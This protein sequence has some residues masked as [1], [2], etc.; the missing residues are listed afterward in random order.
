MTGVGAGQ[1]CWPIA[2][3]LGGS[4]GGSR[5]QVSS[6]RK[7]RMHM[8]T[9]RDLRRDVCR[10][11]AV[12]AGV[13]G[14]LAGATG[15]SAGDGVLNFVVD[16]A[17][18]DANMDGF[19]TGEEFAPLGSDGVQFTFT[20]VNNLVGTTRMTIDSGRGLH[21]G[22][23][24]GSLLEFDFTTDTEIDLLGYTIAGGFFILGN[25]TFDIVQGDGIFS[26]DNNAN[27]EGSFE[28][29]GGAIRMMPGET[30]RFVV[31]NSG[32][33]IQSFISEWSYSVIP[34]PGS[35]GLVALAGVVALR[36]RR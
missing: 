29:N 15:A 13:A 7:L 14:L 33:A 4:L 17:D 19:L 16:P 11:L 36:R 18:F 32:A 8:E 30:F 9:C 31:T 35:A 20:P 3:G 5:V 34:A 21:F 23:G 22:G 2:T 24:G 12:V 1:R 28:F 6:E 10:R 25:P 27:V 26:A